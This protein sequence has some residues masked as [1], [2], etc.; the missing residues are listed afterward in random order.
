MHDEAILTLLALLCQKIGS[1]RKRKKKCGIANAASENFRRSMCRIEI[2]LSEAI[3][4]DIAV[5]GA[6]YT[7]TDQLQKNSVKYENLT[8][9]T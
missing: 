7:T 8:K 1:V 5:R 4:G 9:Q 3:F 2:S 6:S